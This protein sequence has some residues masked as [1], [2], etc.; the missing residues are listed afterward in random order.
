M[1][2]PEIQDY[3]AHIYYR[4][5]AEQRRAARL[6]GEMRHRFKVVLGRWRYQ[7]VGPHPRPMY[8]VA[9]SVS[10]FA[11]L[12]PWLCLRRRGLAVFIHPNT[13][14]PLADH[15]DHAIWLGEMLALRLDRL[16]GG[17]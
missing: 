15:R 12:V 13:G 8:Q 2:P 14:D 6:R 10:E 9:F 17:A 11:R 5:A 16:P 4:D 1:A 7:P 3:H